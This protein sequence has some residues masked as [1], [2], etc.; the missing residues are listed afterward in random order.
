MTDRG[1][2]RVEQGQKRVRGFVSGLPVFDTTRPVLV[3]EV[4]YYPAYYVP[5]DDVTADLLPSD[6]TRHSP[7][8]GDADLFDVR[9]GATTVPGAA[10]R[11]AASPIP[12]LRELVRFEWDALDEWFEEDE[13]VY[14]HPR[15]P[16]TRV[17]VLAS[18]RHVRVVVDGITVAESSSPRILFETGLP[19]RYYLPLTDVRMDLLEPSETRSHCPYKGTASYWS[20]V[21]EGRRYDDALWCYRSPFPESQKIAGLGCFY[22]EKVD[23]YVDGA[24]QDRPRTHFS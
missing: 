14:T 4:P 20:L 9:V 23:L 18:S 5:V 24:P 8:R 12:E 1:R 15:D 11:Y 2:V 17:D 19:P 21:V 3:W 22:N 13:P 7:S 16:H 10:S 6:E